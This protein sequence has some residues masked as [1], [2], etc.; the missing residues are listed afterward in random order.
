M[1]W[2]VKELQ[3]SLLSLLCSIAEDFMLQRGRK[4]SLLPGES[5]RWRRMLCSHAFLWFLFHFASSSIEWHLFLIS[6]TTCPIL[7][8]CLIRPGPNCVTSS[9]TTFFLLVHLPHPNDFLSFL[10]FFKSMYF[11]MKSYR[12]FC[13]Y[14]VVVSPPMAFTCFSTWDWHYQLISHN[15]H[16]TA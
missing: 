7:W 9:A 1:T 11:I 10:P 8:S 12:Y 2:I 5:G 4:S 16:R 13:I 14:L 15:A 6:S 3:L